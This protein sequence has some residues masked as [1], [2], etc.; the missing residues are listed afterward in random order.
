MNTLV[1]GYVPGSGI[2]AIN[3]TIADGVIPV[4]LVL[5]QD[6]SGS[7]V[8]AAGDASTQINGQS[9]F[10]VGPTPGLNSVNISLLNNGHQVVIQGLNTGSAPLNVTAGLGVG[11][12]QIQGG[13]RIG[14]GMRYSAGA[15]ST[16]T[17]LD[18]I[19]S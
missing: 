11:H 8:I 13:S 12:L 2:L 15:G 16:C 10:S 3:L 17:I 14:G 18:K 5:S 7:P 6:T 9:S 4:N 1:G 19:G